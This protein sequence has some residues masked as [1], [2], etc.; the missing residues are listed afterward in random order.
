MTNRKARGEGYL[1]QLDID[2]TETFACLDTIR[3]SIAS[4]AQEKVENLLAQCKINISKW[5]P[6][7]R[8]SR[9]R[10]TGLC[11]QR[12]REKGPKTQEGLIWVKTS[13]VSV[14]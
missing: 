13:I 9:G 12:Q 4:A 2:C 7:R 6:S 5:I 10:I 8:N 14:L 11:G 1:Q 3:A